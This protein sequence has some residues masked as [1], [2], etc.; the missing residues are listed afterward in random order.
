MEVR[1]RCGGSVRLPGESADVVNWITPLHGVLYGSSEVGSACLGFPKGGL[2]PA[3]HLK[4]LPF[5][6]TAAR[7]G[8]IKGR[9]RATFF[10]SA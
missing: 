1:E 9:L 5:K 6:A 8:H 10:R 2:R 4:Q 3:A 7:F